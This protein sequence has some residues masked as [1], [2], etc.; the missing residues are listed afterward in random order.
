MGYSTAFFHGAPNGSM[1]F[2]AFVMQAGVKEY[3]GK[4]EYANDADYDGNWGIWE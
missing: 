3:Y 1:G 4:T 2:N